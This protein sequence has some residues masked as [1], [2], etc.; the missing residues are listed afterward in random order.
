E[1]N[2]LLGEAAGEARAAPA[3]RIVAPKLARPER[4]HKAEPLPL[5]SQSPRD[6]RGVV[7]EEQQPPFRLRPL[8][9]TALRRERHQGLKV[10]A[11]D[12]R[13]RQMGGGGHQVRQEAD[14]LPR[15]LDQDRLVKRH[16]PGRGEATD[17]G[18]RLGVARYQRERHWLEIGRQIARRRALVRAAREL[19]LSSLDHIG[20][21]WEREPNFSPSTT[22]TNLPNLRNLPIRVSAGVIE[23]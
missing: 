2:L 17:A 6:H 23:M 5:T 14:T 8:V 3:Y 16:M 1:S 10:V 18:Q 11:H 19:K 13:Q 22:S 7:L 20:G 12:P 9:Q 4:L 21:A 15:A